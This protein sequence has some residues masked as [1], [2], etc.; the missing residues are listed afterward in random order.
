MTDESEDATLSR[1][2][3]VAA[4][5]GGIAVLAGLL[6]A[7]TNWVVYIG[8]WPDQRPFY[9]AGIGDFLLIMGFISFMTGLALWWYYGLDVGETDGTSR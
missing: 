1:R 5:I 3:L 4:L 8:E 7:A 2:G 6:L 9:F